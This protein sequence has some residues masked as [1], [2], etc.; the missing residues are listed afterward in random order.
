MSYPDAIFEFGI[1]T[2]ERKTLAKQRQHVDNMDA[3]SA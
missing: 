1:S 3:P 2:I